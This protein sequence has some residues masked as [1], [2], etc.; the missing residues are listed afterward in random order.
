MKDFFKLIRYK[1][2]LIIILLQCL[3][4]FCVVNPILKIYELEPL[5]G[6]LDLVFMITATVLIAAG[7]YVINDYFDTKTDTVNRPEEVIIGKNISR[8]DAITIHLIL[9][10][11]ACVLGFL[12]SYR[13]GVWIIGLAYPFISGLLWFYSATY[14]KQFLIGN[15]I[16]AL[17]T[18]IVPLMPAVY[19]LPMQIATNYDTI[20]NNDINI[21]LIFYWAVGYGIFAA[22]T[23]LTREIVKDWEDYEGDKAAGRNSVPMVCGE[24]YTKIITVVLTAISLTGVI[25]MWRNY[26]T[27]ILSSIYI[28]LFIIIPFVIL[29]YKIMKIETKDDCKYIKN[30]YKIIMIAGILYLFVVRYNFLSFLQ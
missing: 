19:E 4:K 22:I 13:I 9:N 18:G 11:I 27:D 16:V 5:F 8:S 1:N 14:K 15:I 10:I 30:F 7:G 20:V 3:I 6:G 29:L 2:L 17:L 12:V 21:Y 24:F 28:S 26:L 23:T 25:Y